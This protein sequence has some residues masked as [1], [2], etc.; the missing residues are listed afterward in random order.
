M[1]KPIPSQ[2]WYNGAKS[3]AIQHNL[4]PPAEPRIFGERDGIIEV[5]I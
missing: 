4:P 2:E 1:C 5:R 3:L